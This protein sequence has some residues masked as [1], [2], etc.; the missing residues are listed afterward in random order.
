MASTLALGDWGYFL[1]TISWLFSLV[2]FA[3]SSWGTCLGILQLHYLN[4]KQIEM[5]R[6]G[7]SNS[8]SQ[9]EPQKF[10]HMFVLTATCMWLFT[11]VN[12]SDSIGLPHWI[13]NR[14]SGYDGWDEWWYNWEYSDKSY[15]AWN[16]LWSLAK[17]NL[18]LVYLHRVYSVF[19]D[20]E[21]NAQ[22]RYYIVALVLLAMQLA[23]L[24]V[25]CWYYNISWSCCGIWL[26]NQ[27][28]ILMTITWTILLFDAI[29]SFYL[30]YLF[31]SSIKKVLQSISYLGDS[32][33]NEGQ[34]EILVMTTRIFTL[35]MVSLISS[36]F[37]QIVFAVAITGEFSETDGHLA[38]YYF[39]FTWN[40]DNAFNVYC[41]FLSL[42]FAKQQYDK[43]C[44]CCDSQC[45]KCVEFMATMRSGVDVQLELSHVVVVSNTVSANTCHQS[46]SP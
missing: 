13:D 19:K 28:D 25:W 30:I 43:V 9:H 4:E 23:L 10:L 16:V 36:I 46:D 35:A 18:Y 3:I 11:G 15:L 45:L 33:P 44:A 27:Y 6:S 20:T 1:I 32:R 40:I 21:Y 31:V 41:L 42:P 5:R 38:M 14:N 26:T 7:H 24:C 29:I 8:N 22:T 2:S 37:Y 17:I 39:T 12:I 34:K